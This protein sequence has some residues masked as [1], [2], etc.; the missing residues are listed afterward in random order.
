LKWPEFWN[1]FKS[2]VDKQ[3]IA[4]VSKFSY[5]KGAL[6]GTAFIAISGIAL[7][8]DN[9][10][11][12]VTLLKQKF[13]RPDSIIE[14][15]YS[16]LQHLSTASQRF[17]DVKRTFENIERILQQL[18]LQGENVN[19]QKILVH[20]ILSKFPLEVILKLEHTKTFGQV[21][22]MELL[23]QLLSQYVQMQENAQRHLAAN[24]R[25]YGYEMRH[26]ESCLGYQKFNQYSSHQG[27]NA[28]KS[29]S[30][31]VET[32]ATNIQRKGKFVSSSWNSCVFCQGE[33]FS[34]ECDQYRELAE[35]KQ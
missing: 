6:H 17:S 3:N 35:C 29:S 12:A 21:W 16:K 4:K 1:V 9:Y 20:Q 13:G 5:L 19:A 24:V 18:E 7:T 2:S 22:T 33:N 27:R 32:Y 30:A 11:V 34:D 31:P 28:T 26:G 23:R 14:M 25:G 10:D 15:L 8:N